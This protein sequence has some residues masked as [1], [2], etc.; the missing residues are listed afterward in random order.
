MPWIILVSTILSFL[1]PIVKWL[2]EKYLLEAAHEMEKEGHPFDSAGMAL[3][4]DR[5]ISRMP[6]GWLWG[7]GTRRVAEACKAVCT[8]RSLDIYA[9]INGALSMKDE[10]A[11]AIAEA[12]NN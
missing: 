7:G 4:W 2:L 5:A 8:W 12:L 6:R 10:D 1:G 11:R 3:L 9:G